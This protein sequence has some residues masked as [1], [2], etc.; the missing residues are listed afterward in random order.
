MGNDAPVAHPEIGP[1]HDEFA[2]QAPARESDLPESGPAMTIQAPPASL[3]L[4]VRRRIAG[5]TL[6]ALTERLVN[7]G[8]SALVTFAMAIFV[9]P[10]EAG[11]YAFG[12]LAL[13]FAQ[14]AGSWA[15]QQVGVALWR[16]EGGGAALRR[17]SRVV[18]FASAAL[19]LGSLL[20]GRA[21]GLFGDP[22]LQAMLPLVLVAFVQ[23][24]FVPAITL[25]QF[26]GEWP[27]LTR[28]QTAGSALSLIVSLPLLA[29]CG[30]AAAVLQSVIA[31]TVFAL[32]AARRLRAPTPDRPRVDVFRR[33]VLPTMVTG[34]FGWA[35]G[36]ADRLVVAVLAGAG[37]LGLF[38]IAV[39]VSKTITDAV[40][41][42]IL[43]V[44]RFRLASAETPEERGAVLCGLLLRS[45]AVAL[46]LQVLVS[47][48]VWPL[49][50]VLA[51][52]WRPALAVVPLL[53]MSGVAMAGQYT[54]AAAVVES[55]HARRLRP[56][57]IAS[58]VLAVGAGALVAWSLPIG[59]IA[60]TVADIATFAIVFPLMR[61]DIDLR[62]RRH[63]ALLMAAGLL[64]G[65]GV[66]GLGALAA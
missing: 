62:T 29:F 16:Y 12:M 31:E 41:N 40:L 22:E 43:N 59:A 56:S 49:H 39:A 25:R 42:G 63:L 17:V 45:A 65:V 26:S 4:R 30:V 66:Y 64:F 46:G 32:G 2:S 3:G 23:G 24:W 21:A 35:N 51:A 18:A 14:A 60:E 7:R 37:P 57:N 52:E 53:A 1:S 38:A 11:A 27:R 15:L 20:A 58:L 44:L 28:A 50:L 19:V 36:Q 34:L 33:F 10:H 55:G 6:M 48:L 9:S 5:P 54:I 47:A 61:A 8:A 13:T